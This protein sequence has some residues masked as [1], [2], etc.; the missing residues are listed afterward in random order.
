MSLFL[1][2][3]SN[4]F[5]FHSVQK[6][7][8]LQI[9]TR[10]YN[11]NSLLHFSDLIA[12]NRTPSLSLCSDQPGLL[13][14]EFAP[15]DLSVCCAFSLKCPF[16]RCHFL[17]IGLKASAPVFRRGTAE[18]WTTGLRSWKQMRGAHSSVDMLYSLR[19]TAGGS[20]WWLLWLLLYD[21]H[22]KVEHCQ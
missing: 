12:Y 2:K 15:W 9:L 21:F 18:G 10:T 5:P 16:P 22:T 4:G 20:P 14:G 7:L 3:S 17:Q 1:P 13:T 6:P 19:S 11:Y 8:S